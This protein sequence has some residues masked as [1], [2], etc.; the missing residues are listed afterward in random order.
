MTKTTVVLTS[1]TDPDRKI[2]AIKNFR[3][4]TRPPEN[5]GGMAMGLREAKDIVDRLIA[6]SPAEIVE[7][8]DTTPLSGSFTWLAQPTATTG[9]DKAIA[10]QFVLDVLSLSDPLTARSIMQLPSYQEIR[11]ALR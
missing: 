6:S 10:L 11:E 3:D 1:V 8:W 7:V 2:Q 9:I 5:V 4:A